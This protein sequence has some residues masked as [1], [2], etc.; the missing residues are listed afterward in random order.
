MIAANDN[1]RFQ[2]TLPNQLIET[3][4][5][6]RAFA[7]AQPADARRQ[8]LKRHFLSDQ[9]DPARQGLVLWKGF[10]DR[11]ISAVDVFEVSRKCNPSKRTASLAEQGPDVF[12]NEAGNVEGILHTRFDCL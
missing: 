1:G 6:L 9:T 5:E 10:K 7:I 3:Q 8:T 12:G 4:A 11:L 2:L